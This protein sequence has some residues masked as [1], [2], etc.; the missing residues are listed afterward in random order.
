M[1]GIIT[2]TD[3]GYAVALK[4]KSN[5]DDACIYHCPKPFSEK[6]KIYFETHD[7]L[8]FIMAIGIVVRTVGPICKDKRF[9]PPVLVLDDQ[10]HHVIS[11]LSGHLGGANAWALRLSEVLG[12]CPVITT[13]SDVNQ[14]L[15]I[16]MLAEKYN[17]ILKD[18]EGAKILTSNLLKGQKV[19]VIG[20]NLIK[21]KNY[22]NHD[23]PNILYVGH[24]KK[25]FKGRSVQLFPRN[26]VLSIGCRKDISYDALKNF[27]DETLSAYGYAIEAIE[28]LVSA[29]VKKD[30]HCLSI[31]SKALKVPAVFYEIEALKTV[32]HLFE[33]SDF[34][35]ETIGVASVSMACGY[36][37]SN[38]GDVLIP[39][40]VREGMTLS[41]WEKREV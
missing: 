15:S 32:E 9:D 26:L 27:V 19:Q 30:E 20:S 29:W 34:V 16:D 33:G 35:K 18:F 2:L 24:E 4:I 7:L 6:V 41:L 12:A 36:L 28:K 8:I 37:G 1:I 3:Q 38:Q 23:S 22:V 21:E 14:L 25:N 13:S 31:L 11:F 10:G 17:L 40:K 39:K 5:M